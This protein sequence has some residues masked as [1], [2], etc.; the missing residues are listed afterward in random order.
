[1]D[2]FFHR[3]RDCNAFSVVIN[4]CIKRVDF[5]ERQTENPFIGNR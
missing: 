3:V 2:V 4:K 1:M 5:S